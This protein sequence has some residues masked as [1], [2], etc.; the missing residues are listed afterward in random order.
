MTRPPPTPPPLPSPTLFRSLVYVPDEHPRGPRL[1]REAHEPGGT[2]PHLA[3]VAGR[4]FELV[5]VGGL[6]R[7]DEHDAGPQCVGVMRDRL[8]PRLAQRSE[9]RRVGKECRSRWSPYH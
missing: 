3:H 7:V 6:D 5:G 8:E 2:L 9:E 1:F 4:A